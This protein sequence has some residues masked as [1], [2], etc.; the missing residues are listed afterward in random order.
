MDYSE[1]VPQVH[2]ELIPIKSL[3]SNQ[4]YQRNLSQAHIARKAENFDL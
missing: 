2:F 3:V 1:Y 4:N